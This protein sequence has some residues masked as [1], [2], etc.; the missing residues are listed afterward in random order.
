MTSCLI[1]PIPVLEDNYAYLIARDGRAVVI[2]PGE[3]GPVRRALSEQRLTLAAIL[4]TH[5][6][7]DHVGGVAALRG[8][9]VPV[10]GPEP[11]PL[12]LERAAVP[13]RELDIG[14]LRFRVIDTPGHAFPHVAFYLPTED[15][16]FSGDCLF[17][18][19]CGRVPGGAM[20]TMWHS[21][22]A[23]N[24]LPGATRV[25]FGHEYT[26]SNLAFAA[27]VE[28]GNADVAERLRR[29][30]GRRA[31]GEPT[32]PSTLAEERRTNPF[33]RTDVPEIRSA[34]RLP[35]GPDAAVF[36]ALRVRKNSFRG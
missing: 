4:L 10:I 9:S 15:A 18:A 26:V 14:D 11:S 7:H 16:L 2:D 27:H 17:G 36:A 30:H 13:D 35:Q 25:Y 12:V 1:Q 24:R 31:A 28:P 34:E 33:L 5:Y 20:E 21:L 19:G 23:L 32:T 6:D 8:P 29:E 22:Q 3:A